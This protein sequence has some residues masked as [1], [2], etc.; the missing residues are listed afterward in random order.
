M[1]QLHTMNSM[2]CLTITNGKYGWTWKK[3]VA[4][5]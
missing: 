3:Q 5:R 2:E 4:M 1:L